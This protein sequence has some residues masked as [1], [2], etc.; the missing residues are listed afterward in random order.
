MPIDVGANIGAHTVPLAKLVGPTGRV[1]AFEPQRHVFQ[2][3]C[4][5]LA[6]N[7]IT[8]TDAMPFAVGM[9]EDSVEIPMYDPGVGSNF[10]GVAVG[11]PII[12]D[13]PTDTVDQCQIDGFV[14]GRIDLIKIDVEGMENDVLIGASQ[15]I[16]AYRPALYVENDRREHSKILAERLREMGYDLYWHLPPLFN[17][18]NYAKNHEDVF[19]NVVSV[20]MLCLP[21]GIM[22]PVELAPVKAFD[23][24]WGTV[25]PA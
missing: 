14:C 8:N 16:K 22:P 5:N 25:L 18:G 1:Y 6:L 11:P 7:Q 19:P 17:P 10:G 12:G 9:F 15:M 2:T 20:N 24:L 23:E 3:L 13:V 21:Y 4:A